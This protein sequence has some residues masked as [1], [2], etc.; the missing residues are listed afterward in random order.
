MVNLL[1]D[2]RYFVYT[3]AVIA[4]LDPGWLTQGSNKA[5]VDMLVRDFANPSSNDPDFP[6]SRSFDWYHGHSWA[7]GLFESADG[8]DEESSS[9]DAFTSYALKMWGIASG[10][11][12]MEARGN[13][14]LALLASSLQNYFLLDS[15]NQVRTI[16]SSYGTDG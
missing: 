16:H 3:A 2:H 8:K 6:F 13:L 10:D 14:M 11:T 9:E 1:T 12:S 15:D 5:W 4:H 7:K